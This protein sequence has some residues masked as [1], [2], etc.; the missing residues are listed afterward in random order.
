MVWATN[1][2]A[3]LTKPHPSMRWR[4][5][6]TVGACVLLVILAQSVA[7]L[8]MFEA[9]EEEFIDEIL[10][11]QIEHSMAMWRTTPQLA[12]PNTADMRLYRLPKQGLAEDVPE[13]YRGLAIGN[14]E[15]FERGHEFHVAVR[16]DETARYVLVYDV[17]IHEER[18]HEMTLITLSSALPLALVTLLLGYTLSGRLATQIEALARRATTPTSDS[19]V[20]PGMER[21]LL[22]IA[23]ALDALEAQQAVL[24][25]R[26]QELTADLAHELWTPLTGIRTDAELLTT[27]PNLPTAANQRALRIIA[28]VDRVHRLGSSLLLLS[29]EAQPGLIE[30]VAL[31]AAVLAA[32]ESL[33]NNTTGPNSALQRL[34]LEGLTGCTVQADASLLDLILRN[35]FENAQR[36]APHGQIICRCLA[37]QPQLEIQDD[38]PGFSDIELTQVFDRHYRGARGRHGLGLSL[39]LHVCTAYSWSVEV[40][41]A[42]SGGALIRIDF[43]TGLQRHNA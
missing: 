4:I 39:V 5:A 1:L 37:S 28:S 19:Y 2:S 12:F 20:Q 38:G 3:T 26:E 25:R 41:N 34:R 31:E 14:F 40:A 6:V 33:Q 17:Q 22:S 29:R 43:G 32:L 21:E 10:T 11:Q 8:M 15:I 13:P 7:L 35:L 9:K 23:Q 30:T 27:L 24:L 18:V 16:D 42:P 36:H